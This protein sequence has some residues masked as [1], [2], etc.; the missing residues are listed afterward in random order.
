[1]GLQMFSPDLLTRPKMSEVHKH[2]RTH[3]AVE[4][5]TIDGLTRLKEMKRRIHVSAHMNDET[6]PRAVETPA[7]AQWR[8]LRAF[9]YGDVDRRIAGKNRRGR[10]NRR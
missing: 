10:P 4:R 3:A 2:G 1:M 9:N 6:D 5:H 8:V 7:L